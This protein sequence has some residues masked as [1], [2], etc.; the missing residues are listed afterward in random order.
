MDMTHGGQV[1]A[2]YFK[3]EGYDVTVAD[4]YRIAPQSMLDDLKE[5]GIKVFV[6]KP[7]PGHYDMVSMPCHCPDIFLEGCTY[8]KR[9]WYSQ[10]VSRYITDGRFRIE[11]TGVKGKT[12]TCYLIAHLLAH[13]GKKVY[14]RSSRGSGPYTVEGH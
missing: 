1:L 6:G 2:P 13:A 9:E 11:V 8:D 5:Q 3:K 7:E 10:S 12:S 14:L 4:V